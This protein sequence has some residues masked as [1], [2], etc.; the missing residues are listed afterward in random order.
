MIEFPFPSSELAARYR[1]RGG[2]RD[3]SP[4]DDLRRWRDESPDATAMISAA[5]DAGVRPVT[6][7]EYAGF[8]ERFAGAFRE[9]GVEPGGVVAVQI[10]SWWQCSALLL[11]CARVGAVCAPVMTTIRPRELERI[12]RRLDARVCVT[13][14]R[15][16]GFEHSAAVA[17]MAPRLPA[18][19][20]RV[21]LGATVA[22]DEIDFSEFFEHTSW[23]ARH[24]MALEDARVDPDRVVLALFT[25]G[26]SGEPKGV[27]HTFNTL[28]A[29]V[30][31]V[32][33]EEPIGP[34]DVI[35]LPHALT[36]LAG[37]FH[38]VLIPLFSGATAVLLDVWD[39]KAGLKLLAE[40]GVTVFGGAPTFWFELI[41]A[42]G[43]QPD[44]LPT[45]RL[46]ISGATTVPGQLVDDVARVFGLPLRT[47]W[48]M[49]EVAG[50][51]WTRADDP[52]DWGKHSD[53]RPGPEARSS[54]GATV[55]S[56]AKTPLRCSYAAREYAWPRW[57]ETAGIC[58][59][60]PNTTTVGTTQ[61]TSPCP[62]A[63]VASASSAERP[64][65][66]AEPS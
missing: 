23:A 49:T 8:V 30:G 58:G 18:L 53:G 60:S 31:Q 6:W 17:E 25:S 55:R 48:A 35:F 63:A 47:M 3:G 37:I 5:A 38:N 10:P 52:Q 57:D 29:G 26:T 9:L 33:G 34:D 12:L 36:H 20:H 21:I 24:P 51:T 1:A 66:S 2:W 13:V 39:G 11:A 7:R 45:L 56:A 44:P 65:V 50:Y 28:H 62:T 61:E 32:V 54:C 16:A 14:D 40:T 4:L 43:E 64:T 22:E 41:A 27:L 59:F 46:A 42:A 19:R 15:W